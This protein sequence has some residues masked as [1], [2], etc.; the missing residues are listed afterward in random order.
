MI[1]ALAQDYAGVPFGNVG[2]GPAVSWGDDNRLANNV[3]AGQILFG[4]GA[5][6]FENQADR[7]FKVLSSF[8]EGRA[9]RVRAGQLLAQSRYSLRGPFGKPL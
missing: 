1:A 3:L 7:F 4:Q 5:V 9:L 2:P 6:C 8:V